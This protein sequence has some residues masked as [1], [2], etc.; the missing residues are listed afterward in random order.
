MKFHMYKRLIN[1]LALWQNESEKFVINLLRSNLGLINLLKPDWISALSTMGLL[2][3]SFYGFFGTHFLEVLI[4]NLN[5]EVSNLKKERIELLSHIN[6][7][8]LERQ[9]SVILSNE[10]NKKNQELIIV[11]NSYF[12][13][14]SPLIKE[15]FSKSVLRVLNEKLYDLKR[16]IKLEYYYGSLKKIQDIE[17]EIKKIDSEKS[18]PFPRT[19][20][21]LQKISDLIDKKHDL[22]PEEWKFKI[23]LQGMRSDDL[24]DSIRLREL[25]DNFRKGFSADPKTGVDIV[26]K[27][28]KLLT[29]SLL[30]KQDRDTV[31]S[32]IINYTSQNSNIYKLPIMVKIMDYD[33]DKEVK[34]KAIIAEKH[35]KAMILDFPTFEAKLLEKINSLKK[36]IN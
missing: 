25:L 1:Q 26:K 12:E 10:L 30:T 8:Q 4:S 18:M 33:T 23:I 27:A 3:L 36:H 21:K 6:S 9:N 19:I 31:Q 20:E 35:V 7:L 29:L 16:L 14:V 11:Y 22:L 24:N 17:D 32:F 15:E 2:I 28:S 34:E 5:Q 13:K